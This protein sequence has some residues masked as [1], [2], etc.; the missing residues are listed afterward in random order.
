MKYS[1]IHVCSTV[2][3]N[4]QK[5]R[6]EKHYKVS[7]MPGFHHSVTVLPL[8]ILRF[9]YTVQPMSMVQPILPY[10]CFVTEAGK[11]LRLTTFRS[12]CLGL[13]WA[14]GKELVVT[15]WA[16]FNILCRI[17]FVNNKLWSKVNVYCL[18]ILHILLMLH[19]RTV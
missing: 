2:L 5:S 18:Y 15:A 10:I 1:F 11:M 12:L 3:I 4:Q 16:N 9:V 19:K 7:V 17:C 13:V 6:V 14:F 8:S